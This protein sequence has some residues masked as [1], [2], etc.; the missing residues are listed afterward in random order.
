MSPQAF[1]LRVTHQQG[2]GVFGY[3]VQEGRRRS[4]CHLSTSSILFKILKALYFFY[5]FFFYTASRIDRYEKAGHVLIYLGF[6][7]LRPTV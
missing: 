1:P 6:L 5:V 3:G 7:E 4:V 2:E